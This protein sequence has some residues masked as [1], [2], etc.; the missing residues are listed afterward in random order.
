MPRKIASNR[1][2]IVGDPARIHEISLS[3]GEILGAPAAMSQ[4]IYSGSDGCL[5]LPPEY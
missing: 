4:K 3:K 1:T 2:S 5:L